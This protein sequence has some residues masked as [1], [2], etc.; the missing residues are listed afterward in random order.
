AALASTTSTASAAASGTATLSSGWYWIRAVES[1]YYHSYLQSQPAAT[2]APAVL[3][4]PATA[5]QFNIVDGQLVY[6]TG[7]GGQELYMWVQD[8]TDK[9]Q[10]ALST[11]FNTTANPYGT[12]AFS[13]DTVDWVD[14]DVNRG[15][16][17]AFYVCPNATTG[18]NDLFINTGAYD[19]LT[20]TGCFDVDIHSYGAATATV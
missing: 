15:N 7:A 3:A 2:P 10:R 20:P 6:N 9:T 13:G 17:G 19:Y 18:E 14:P 8:P 12:F 5:G 11:W 1:P 4:S 16:L